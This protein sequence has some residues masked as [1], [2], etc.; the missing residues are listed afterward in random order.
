MSVFVEVRSSVQTVE[1][2]RSKKEQAWLAKYCD[3]CKRALDVCSAD[4]CER[5]G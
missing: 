5:W 1:R 3:V 2:V 4:S